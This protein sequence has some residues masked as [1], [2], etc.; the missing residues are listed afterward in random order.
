MS[1]APGIKYAAAPDFCYLKY[2][3][4]IGNRAECCL[5]LNVLLIFNS[6]PYVLFLEL[7]FISINISSLF[8]KIL[9]PSPLFS[10]TATDCPSHYGQNNCCKKNREF[11]GRKIQPHKMIC[12]LHSSPF[13]APSKRPSPCRH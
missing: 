4:A 13:F 6:F 12:G 2:E 9:F 3:W 11:C 7:L 1:Q 5:V 8:D 10:I